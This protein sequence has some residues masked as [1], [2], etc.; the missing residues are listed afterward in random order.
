MPDTYTIDEANEQHLAV[1]LRGVDAWNRWRNNNPYVLPV[2]ARGDFH[3]MDLREADLSNAVLHRC[4]LAGASLDGANLYQAEMYGADLRG[5]QLVGADMRG[6]KLHSADLRGANLTAADLYRVDFI[7]TRLDGTVFR[8]ARCQT[9]AFSDVDLSSAVALELVDHSGPSNLDISTLVR[10][11]AAVPR[12]FLLGAGVPADLIEAIMAA[13]A[14]PRPVEINSVFISYSSADEEFATL[15]HSKLRKRGV[16][17]WFAPKDMKPGLRIHE[18]IDE[19]IHLHDRVMLVLSAHS[20]ASSWVT[21][22]LRK[23]M[24]RERRERRRVVFPVGLLPFSELQA[25]ECFDAD[26]GIDL[27]VAVRE[28]FVPDFSRWR[29]PQTFNA[30]VERLLLAL[31]HSSAVGGR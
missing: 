23:A 22:E 26:L 9:T 4:N 20:L 5:A 19:A 24:R 12:T 16:R 18:Q 3:E 11:A 7:S 17:V 13:L 1:F 21:T 30:A 29:E 6:S 15:L 2:L 10:S 27:A 14:G 25:W 8:G 31:N 28:Y